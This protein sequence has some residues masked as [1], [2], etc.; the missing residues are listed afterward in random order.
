MKNEPG[1]KDTFISLA[2][3]PRRNGGMQGAL[4]PGKRVAVEIAKSVS[5]LQNESLSLNCLP[6]TVGLAQAVQSSTFRLSSVSKDTLSLNSEVLE[7]LLDVVCQVR[8]DHFTPDVS[9]SDVRLLN[10]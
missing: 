4:E 2:C 9:D 6:D 1:R 7:P 5:T 8:F 10:P 3:I